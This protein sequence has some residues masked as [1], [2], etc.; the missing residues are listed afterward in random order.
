MPW[1]TELD[2][3]VRQHKPSSSTSST[4][5]K[6]EQIVDWIDHS[7]EDLIILSEASNYN[8]MD[9]KKSPLLTSATWTTFLN[10]K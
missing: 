1:P 7:S 2:V 4:A 9:Q 5:P 8:N 6:A 10:L 3:E